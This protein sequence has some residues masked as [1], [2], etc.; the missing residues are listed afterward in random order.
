MM[1]KVLATKQKDKILLPVFLFI[2]LFWGLVDPLKSN[3]GSLDR[4]DIIF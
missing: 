2:F 4:Q 1:K 3:K